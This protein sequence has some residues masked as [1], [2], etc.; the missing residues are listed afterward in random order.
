MMPS[1]E[2]GTDGVRRQRAALVDQGELDGYQFDGRGRAI[3][4]WR[5]RKDELKFRRLCASLKHRRWRKRIHAEDGEAQARRRAANLVQ[6]AK[7][8]DRIR[9]KH[10]AAAP[11]IECACGSTWCRAPGAAGQMQYCSDE[12]RYAAKLLRMRADYQAKRGKGRTRKCGRCQRPGHNR[13]RC[14]ER[15]AT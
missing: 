1:A 6:K 5:E 7:E 10:R 11:V 15:E 8:R 9:A 13:R 4:Q 14:P 2:R 3:E 12:C